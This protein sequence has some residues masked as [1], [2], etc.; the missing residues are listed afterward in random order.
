M[1]T[2]RKQTASEPAKR[3]TE[4]QTE[5]ETS[6]NLPAQRPR[7]NYVAEVDNRTR[8]LYSTDEMRDFASFD[9]AIALATEKYGPLVDA[10]DVLGDGFA[11]LNRNEKKRLVGVPILFM[12][13]AVHTGDFGPFIA[14][15]IAA[16]NHDGGSSKY[17]VVDGSTGIADTLI[18]YGMR[19]GRNGGLLAKHGLRE[20]TYDF[21]EDCGGAV[22]VNHKESDETRE[23]RVGP[24]TTYYIDLSA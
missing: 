24:A 13:W 20:S 5:K 16:R 7:D 3:Q 17:I 9:E 18:D 19:T 22:K 6:K 1:P 8:S 14:A 4:M 10:A 2:S 15:R 12:E 11:L 23:H 21:C